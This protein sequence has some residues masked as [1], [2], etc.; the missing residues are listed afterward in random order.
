MNY[1]YSM[2]KK[3]CL[4]CKKKFTTEYEVYLHF[5]SKQ[6][7]KIRSKKRKTRTFQDPII[8]LGLV[9]KNLVDIQQQA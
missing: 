9:Q 3:Q 8:S 1:F 6:I 5:K 7:E 4:I 2:K